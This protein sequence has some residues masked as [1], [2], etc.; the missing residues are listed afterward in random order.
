MPREFVAKNSPQ[1]RNKDK[2]TQPKIK[3]VE[4]GRQFSL[5]KPEGKALARTHTPHGEPVVLTVAIAIGATTAEVQVVRVAIIVPS[6][7]PPDPVAANNVLRAGVEVA[8]G[9]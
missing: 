6:T 3:I 8:G 4:H 9:S 2:N 5:E 7:R 1:I